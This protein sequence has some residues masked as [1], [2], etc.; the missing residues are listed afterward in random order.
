MF[1]RRVPSSLAP[2]AL[3]RAVEARHLAGEAI[4]DLTASNPTTADLPYPAKAILASLA[5]TDALRYDPAPAGLAGARAAIADLYRDTHGL[6]IAPD[7]IVLTASSSEAYSW[8]L[9]LTCDPGDRVLVPAPSY[10]LFDSL[11]AL[12]STVVDRYPLAYDGAWHIDRHAFS[13]SLH[14]RTRIVSCVHPNNPTGSF[15]TTDEAAWLDRTCADR[16][17]AIV[18]DEVFSEYAFGAS[19]DRF[20]TFARDG[21]ALTF[22]LG[23]LSKLAGLPQMKLGWIVVSGPDALV[24]EAL[25][26][27]EWI[28]DSYLSVSTPIQLAAPSLIAGRVEV[29][30]AIRA[31]TRENLGALRAALA[32]DATGLSSLLHVEGGWYATLRLPATRSEESWVLSFLSDDGVLVQ[33][34]YFYDFDREVFVVLSLLTPPARFAAGITRVLERVAREA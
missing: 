21:H 9:Q 6:T 27:L 5:N 13:Q 7:R 10:P 11:A 17:L 18:S 31:R 12:Q 33:P 32:R 4:L 26:R 20:A 19:S 3:A 22:T 28:A 23:G 14:E 15:V 16:C 25:Q 1:S 30:D 34:G 8:V 2:N 29:R 24:G